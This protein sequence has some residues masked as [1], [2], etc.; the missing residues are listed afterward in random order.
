M[1]SIT[2]TLNSGM[3][4]RVRYTCVGPVFDVR[5]SGYNQI[6]VYNTQPNH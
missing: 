6:R 3:S 4:D 1:Q 5:T 2:W